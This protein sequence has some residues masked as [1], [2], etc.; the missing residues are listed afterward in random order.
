MGAGKQFFEFPDRQNRDLSSGSTGGRSGLIAE[1]LQQKVHGSEYKR[2]LLEG[3]RRILWIIR[4]WLPN[5]QDIGSAT[6]T[7][8]ELRISPTASSKCRP[9]SIA[10]VA[11]GC[12]SQFEPDDQAEWFASLTLV[13]STPIN[14]ITQRMG[15]GRALQIW[16]LEVSTAGFYC[17]AV[18]QFSR[19]DGRLWLV[20]TEQDP[21]EAPAE[22]AS[23]T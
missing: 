19:A 13:R 10:A 23:S 2:R 8:G 1:I 12:Q 3:E 6:K 5:W 14:N 16:T 4:T 20:C 11:A 17:E 22:T 9:R 15:P 7:V 21:V 18:N